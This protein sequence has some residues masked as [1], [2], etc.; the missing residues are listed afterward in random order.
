MRDLITGYKLGIAF[1]DAGNRVAAANTNLLTISIQ[2]RT[3]KSVFDCTL[4][5]HISDASDQDYRFIKQS[6][7]HSPD[8]MKFK[9]RGNATE[10]DQPPRRA[11]ELWKWW[12]VDDSY[13]LADL[14][15]LRAIACQKLRLRLMSPTPRKSQASDSVRCP[16]AN[17][18][19]PTVASPEHTGRHHK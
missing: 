13:C 14:T 9:A 17:H 7:L 3:L 10:R 6:L 12:L 2:D 16:S 1:L 8:A 19:R 18:N 11:H 4:G 5:G 15:L